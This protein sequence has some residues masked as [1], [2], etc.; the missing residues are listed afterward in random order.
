[1]LHKHYVLCK[2]Y[3]LYKNMLIFRKFFHENNY[4]PIAIVYLEYLFFYIKIAILK[5]LYK[6]W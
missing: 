6:K 3:V 4:Y 1:M 2:K 5:V